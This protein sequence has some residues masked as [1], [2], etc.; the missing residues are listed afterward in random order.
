MQA[1]QELR[2]QMAPTAQT[3]R[4][5]S[6]DLIRGIAVLGILLANITAFSQP[7]MAYYWPP[8]LLSGGSES[9]R[10]AW[11]V[12]YVLVDGK[13]RGL[14]SILFG[15]GLA[16]FMESKPDIARALVLQWRRLAWLILFGLLH[17]FLLFRGDILFG[18]GIAGFIALFFLRMSAEK[19]L[20]IGI[21]WALVA[22]GAQVLSYLTPALIE[23]GAS[24]AARPDAIAYYS[25]YW[26][27]RLV[28][29]QAQADVMAQGSYLDVL[30]YRLAE[31]S[32]LL[33]GYFTIGFFETV[34]LMLI[35]MG[36]YRSGLFAPGE[37]SSDWRWAAVATLA[38]G[39]AINLAMGI[40]VYRAG[41][42]P[43]LTQLAF[44]GVA[45]VANSFMLLGGTALL[46]HWAAHARENWLVERLSQAGRMALSNYV[47]TSLVMALVFQGW[48]GGL[49]GT[50]G[51]LDALPVVL[52]G[53]ALIIA[54]SR[55][56]MARYLYGPLEWL[57]RCLTYWRRF[58]LKRA[59]S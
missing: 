45:G 10:I 16:L 49:Y 22:S 9:D 41:F 43:Y 28:A 26:Q 21:I 40:H 47:G 6:L 18:Y 19:L 58:P 7:S 50:L 42:P 57:W 54:L 1:D 3:D 39:L 12:Q 29:A 48:A 8:A 11:L 31:E 20:A 36:F 23:A 5:R 44:F 2:T 4:L 35:G 34:P 37:D 24:E 59:K 51:K 14:F 15:A 33:A 25:D 27:E 56:W 13:F 30:R 46:A 55:I 38:A 53:W 32:G 17:F 52:L